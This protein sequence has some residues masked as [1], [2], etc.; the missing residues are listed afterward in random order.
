M[1]DPSPE[2]ALASAPDDDDDT[3]VPVFEVADDD[4]DADDAAAAAAAAVVAFINV[5]NVTGIDLGETGGGAF[6]PPPPPLPLPAAS[7]GLLTTGLGGCMMCDM[8]GGGIGGYVGGGG[9]VT[10]CVCAFVCVCG[11]GGGEEREGA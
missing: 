7:F 2:L 6:L 1:P 10:R 9:R 4:D 5:I 11:V 8:W 3:M